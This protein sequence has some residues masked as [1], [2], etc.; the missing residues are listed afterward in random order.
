MPKAKIVPST[1]RRTASKT[2]P[3]SAITRVVKSGFDEKV[4][5]QALH[6]ERLRQGRLQTLEARAQYEG[7]R[8]L[9]VE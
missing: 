9:P 1:K 6:H 7:G 4:P 2:K 5:R 8:A 3:E